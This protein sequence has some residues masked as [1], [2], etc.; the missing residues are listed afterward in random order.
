MNAKLLWLVIGALVLFTAV[1]GYALADRSVTAD[2]LATQVTYQQEQIDLLES[3]VVAFARDL[4][5]AEAA[6]VLERTDAS[7]MTR[8]LDDQTLEVGSVTLTFDG[9][10]LTRVRAW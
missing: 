2:H 6:S 1:A 4:T 10:R 3:M 7:E 9:A 8:S 5:P